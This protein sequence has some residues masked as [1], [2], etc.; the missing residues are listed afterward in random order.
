MG[1]IMSDWIYTKD[2]LPIVGRYV[3]VH[4][5]K[6]NWIDSTDPKG[7]YHDVAK[8]VKGISLEEREAMKNGDLPDADMNYR[9]NLSTGN[10]MMVT[11]SMTYTSA[12]E[13][14]NNER[15]YVWKTFGPSSYFGQ[16]VDRWLPIPEEGV[17]S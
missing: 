2:E 9:T 13:G 11:R 3:L 16:E 15:P 1:R 17:S 10:P 7:V 8:M 5:V 4:L 14:M 12:D 6:T